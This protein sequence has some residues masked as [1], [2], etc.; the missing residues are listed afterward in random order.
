M[1]HSKLVDIFVIVLL[2][3]ILLPIAFT[4]IF[5]A[6]TTGWDDNTTTIFGYIP[7]IAV[8]AVIIILIASYIQRK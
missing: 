5:N 1:A 6:N 7:I 4:L 3:A 8:V 2:G